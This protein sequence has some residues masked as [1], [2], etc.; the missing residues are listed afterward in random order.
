M[1]VPAAGEGPPDGGTK[2]AAPRKIQVRTE[3]DR[4]I[5]KLGGLVLDIGPTGDWNGLTVEAYPEAG[6]MSG[7]RVEREDW[8][9]GRMG[10]LE[11]GEVSTYRV[12]PGTAS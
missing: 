12:R 9:R 3:P 1:M 5:V 10:P 4:V 11:P 8:E 6:K 7:A 2:M